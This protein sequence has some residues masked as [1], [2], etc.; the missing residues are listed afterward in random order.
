[1]QRLVRS[2]LKFEVIRQQRGNG[3]QMD[4]Y[5]VFVGCRDDAMIA[6]GQEMGMISASVQRGRDK[7]SWSM[8]DL[9]TNFDMTWY[10]QIYR[11]HGRYMIMVKRVK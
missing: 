9:S 6:A 10:S 1:M 4:K 7:I 8:S 5:S 3:G 11:D 2:A